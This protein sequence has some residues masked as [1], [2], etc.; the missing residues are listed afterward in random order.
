MTEFNVEKMGI[1]HLVDQ[2]HVGESDFSVAK[3]FLQRLKN[4][5]RKF[6]REQRKAVVRYALQCHHENQELYRDV[7]GGGWGFR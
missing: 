6:T 1:R 5:E 7:M 3:S 4:S 2:L